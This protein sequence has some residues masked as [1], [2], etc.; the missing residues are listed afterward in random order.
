MNGQK[1]IENISQKKIGTVLKIQK[2]RQKWQKSQ[3]FELQALLLK[4]N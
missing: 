4:M 1:N 3:I 2:I